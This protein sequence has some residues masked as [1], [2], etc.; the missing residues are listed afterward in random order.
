MKSIDVIYKKQTL[1][2]T[3]FWGDNRICL[4]AKNPS[5]I[6]LS[7]MKFVGGHPDEW[8]IFIDD[9]TYDEKTEITDIYGS[10]INMQ[11]ID[12]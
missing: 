6:H 3:R 11:E 12:I 2:L 4:Y 9:L 7:K 10:P 5:Q 1:R 8:C